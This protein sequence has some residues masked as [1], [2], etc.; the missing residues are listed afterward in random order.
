[1][2]FTINR[3]NKEDDLLQY[4]A[5][6]GSTAF[7][8]YANRLF[9]TVKLMHPGESFKVDDLVKEDTRDLFIKLL[10]WF[11]ISGLA[12]DYCFNNTFTVFRRIQKFTVTKMYKQRVLEM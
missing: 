1:M 6:M 11:I 8:Q 12:P 2:D 3:L 4:H 9:R 10:C 7:W 5:K